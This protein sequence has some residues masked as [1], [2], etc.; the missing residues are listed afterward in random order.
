MTAIGSV[1]AMVAID[2]NNAMNSIDVEVFRKPEIEP[3]HL[4]LKAVSVDYS[5]FSYSIDYILQP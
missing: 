3:K 4:S 5:K 1:A 2:T